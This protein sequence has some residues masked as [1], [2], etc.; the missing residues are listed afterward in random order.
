M[1]K[2]LFAFLFSVLLVFGL[3][4]TCPAAVI[5][6]S[7]NSKLQS[8]APDKQ[9]DVIVT[10]S[11]RVDINAIRDNVQ[12]NQNSKADKNR[13][14]A[15]IILAL[16]T[17]AE[18]TQ[19][20]LKNFLTLKGANNIVSYWI[21]N[22]LSFTA[23][24]AVIR[25]LA[26]W[27]GIEN[28]RLNDTLRIP[29]TVSA[30][31]ALP[32]WNLAAI[33]APEL[34][35][36]GYTG[37][38]V[39]IAGVDTGVDAN[40]PDLL[41]RWRGGSNS[42]FDPNGQHTEPYDADGHG[43]QTMGIM[44]AG[45]VSGTA[46]GVA[47]GAQWIAV[48]IFNDAGVA[49][50]SSIHSGYQWLL[51]PD[52]NPNTGDTPDIVNNSWGLRDNVNEC[53]TEFETDI[54]TL[55]AA[56]IA[57]VFSGGN[58]GPYAATSISPSN[59]AGNLSVGAV[60]VDLAVAGFSSRGPS[61]CDGSIY[62]QVVAPGVSVKTTDLTFGGFTPNSYTI[63]SGSSFSAPHVTGAMALLLS[64]YPQETVAVLEAALKDTALDLGPA[65]PDND[66]GS[67]MID[68]FEAYQR[69]GGISAAPPVATN[70]AYT[71][72]E[73]GTLRAD[74]VPPN[75]AGVLGNDTGA[76]LEAVL[77][78]NVSNG[79]LAL[80]PAGTFVYTHNG[81]Q[82]TGDSFT[83]KAR[84]TVTLAESSL[85]TVSIAV[86]PVNDA[87]M[88]VNDTYAT[89]A[90]STLSIAA[91]GV[92]GND[93]DADGDA[94]TAILNSTVSGGTLTLNSNGSFSYTPNPG[95]LSDSFTYKAKDAVLFSSIVTVT[96]TVSAPAN[97][98]PVAVDDNATTR[99]N[100]AVFI[101]LIA[102]DTDA[103]NN[104]KDASGN[105]PAGRIN[106]VTQPGQGGTVSKVT[107]GVTYTPRRNFRGTDSFTY[108][109]TDTGT[110]PL[111][112][113]TAT[114]RVNVTN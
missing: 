12:I 92:L 77:V 76:S 50:F 83:Y 80:A 37:A 31:S 45:D 46:V 6:P 88:A 104:L 72:A 35:A 24:P 62:P 113:N 20:L 44:L 65:G 8:A 99:R 106:I 105:V 107:N 60:D 93:S 89:L 22:G 63:V 18:N 14:R 30:V 100:T 32:E 73:G 86:T 108:S 5:H 42:W 13:L 98:A 52:G 15:A 110:P 68:V 17:K 64:A 58:E 82:T 56:G 19:K 102:N 4:V 3:G 49:S 34:W 41:V 1:K 38:G 10:L 84:N 78:G 57:V 69:V 94:L 74:G 67:G 21:F 90:G 29:E 39:V 85:A 81:S 9:I 75:P 101:N 112:S 36:L 43:T 91:P 55:K 54:L 79:S 48:K 87:P 103:Q 16:R 47:P 33:G 109:V 51:D 111:T 95:T 40:H 59:Y 23:P 53:I 97:T 26:A 11:D 96:I 70:D 7:L 71:V 61:S 2:T 114:V 66:S 25:D 28:I 27:P